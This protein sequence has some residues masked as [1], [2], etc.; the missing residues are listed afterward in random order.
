M[1]SHMAAMGHWEL[2]LIG[3]SGM[4][5]YD[6]FTLEITGHRII[7]HSRHHIHTPAD[8]F[9]MHTD[10][11]VLGVSTLQ[12]SGHDVLPTVCVVL[13][14]LNLLETIVVLTA[15]GVSCHTCGGRRDICC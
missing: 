5:L 14:L 12:K 2:F 3:L 11:R 4:A 7:H 9:P 10:H 8:Q 1:V 13:V 6:G 15:L